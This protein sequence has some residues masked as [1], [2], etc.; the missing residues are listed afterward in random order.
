M[1]IRDKFSHK[2]NEQNACLKNVKMQG[3]G[4]ALVVNF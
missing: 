1:K 2:K 3:F 4:L